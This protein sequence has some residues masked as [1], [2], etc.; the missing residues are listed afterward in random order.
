[1]RISSRAIIFKGNK[2]LLIYRE[3]DGEQ[4]YVFPG[5]KIE[6]GETM[7][8]CIIRECKEELGITINVKKYVYEVKGVDFIQHF[9]VCDWLDGKIGT[10]DKE[11]YDANRKGGIQIPMLIDIQS[12]KDLNVVSPPIVKQLF[13]DID[14]FGLELDTEVKQIIEA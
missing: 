1:M 6:D 5:G 13:D 4:Y 8:Q 3:R 2:A 12:I 10:G 7:E 11:E 14:N 9:F